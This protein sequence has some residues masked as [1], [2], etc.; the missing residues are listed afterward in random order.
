MEGSERGGL[1]VDEIES[2]GSEDVGGAVSRGEGESFLGFGEGGLS[3]SLGLGPMGSGAGLGQ[4][5]GSLCQV[6]AR[7]EGGSV[8]LVV[9]V[10]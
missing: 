6:T 10:G 5:V 9:D 8:G 4:V 2:H 3:V 7:L 1:A